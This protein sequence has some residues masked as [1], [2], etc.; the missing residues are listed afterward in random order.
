MTDPCEATARPLC[1][2]QREA[3]FLG[4]SLLVQ[5]LDFLLHGLRCSSQLICAS[6]VIDLSLVSQELLAGLVCL[7]L[8]NVLR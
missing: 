2:D 7:Q 4:L 8:M 3:L 6:L 5:S 1:T